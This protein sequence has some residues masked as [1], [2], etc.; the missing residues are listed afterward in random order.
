MEA[1]EAADRIREA[2]EE[3]EQ[4]R[5][6]ADERF[7]RRAAVAVGVLAMLLAI[8]HLAGANATKDMINTNIL[9][10]DAYAFYQAK[11]IRQTSTRLA[12]E[13]LELQQLEQPNLPP[14]AAGQLQ[15]RRQEYQAAVAQFESDPATGEGKQELLARAQEYQE[16]RGRAQR[17][18][19]NFE[20]AEALFQIAIV[21][22]SVGIVAAARWLLGLGIGLGVLATL[23]MLN[24]FFLLVS[25]PL[26]ERAG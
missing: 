11:N 20:Y 9:A 2:A 24:G 10:S 22:G 8:A 15:R 7:R 17:Q 6:A 25:L 23:L 18:S 4:T 14:E 21:L 19:P 3:Q 5:R 1:T 16:Q 12:D 13:Q 26:G